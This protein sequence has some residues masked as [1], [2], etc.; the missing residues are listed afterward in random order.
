MLVL[1]P[2]TP[3]PRGELSGPG[4]RFSITWRF[5]D[6]DERYRMKLSNGVLIHSRQ[7]LH[8]PT[9]AQRTTDLTVPLTKP[10]LPGLFA[11]ASTGGIFDGDT[12]VPARPLASSKT[13][14][15]LSRVTP[16]S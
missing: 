8:F 3:D 9:P 5:T 2:V 6:A 1:D 14:P 12:P 10:R 11:A 16:G 7:R 15:G 13:R 4:E